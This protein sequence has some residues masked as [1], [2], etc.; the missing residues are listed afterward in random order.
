[1]K[2]KTISLCQGKGSLSHNNR[3]FHPKNVDPSRTKDNVT[4]VSIPIEQAYDTLFGAAVERYNAKQKRK[5]RK[6]QNGYFEYQFNHK[7][8][9][10][11]ITSAD[12]RKSFYEDV[13]QIGTKDDTGVGTADAE[14]AAEC[15]KEYMNGFRARN[16]NFYVF[17]A[18][19]HVDEA[20]PHLHIDYI[21]VGHYTR[22]VDTQNGIAQALKEMGYGMGKD[23]IARWRQSEYE[24]LKAI[25][26]ERGIK[27][28]EPKK[29]RGYSYSCEEYKEIQKEKARLTEELRPFREMSLSVQESGI[30]STKLPFV[31][32]A[33]VNIED[34]EMLEK[35]KKA[36]IVQKAESKRL[37]DEAIARTAELD[38]REKQLAVQEADFREQKRQSSAKI[39]ELLKEAEWEKSIA[40][41]TRQRA[42]MTLSDADRIYNKQIN[43]NDRLHETEMKLISANKTH[44]EYVKVL[45]D[46]ARFFGVSNITDSE[47]VIE[48]HQQYIDKVKEFA[49][50]M[51]DE[52]CGGKSWRVNYTPQLLREYFSNIKA[53]VSELEKENEESKT[54]ISKLKARLDKIRTAFS[55]VIRAIRMFTSDEYFDELSRKGKALADGIC[56]CTLTEFENSEDSDIAEDVRRPHID[57]QIRDTAAQ[58]YEHGTYERSSKVQ[59]RNTYIR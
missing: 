46:I 15:L 23:A 11:V 34:L 59:N 54:I 55:K 40:K 2:E 14:T 57:A 31:N 37:R 18:V 35:E 27:I 28:S 25:C 3:D 4:F 16:P 47:A 26:S 8:S 50:V 10:N 9:P 22:G 19:L 6:I 29:S 5:D 56:Y 32:A 1:M 17:N 36:V 52:E 13:V 39:E 42:E 51:R 7:I 24:I 33:K 48:K 53:K 38:E 12:K 30:K 49:D 20:T 44:Q 41:N 45:T 43:I 21:P 58:F